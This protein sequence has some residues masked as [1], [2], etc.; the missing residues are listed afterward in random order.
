VHRSAVVAQQNVE[1]A[2]SLLIAFSLLDNLVDQSWPK[3]AD[4]LGALFGILDGVVAQVEAV[5]QRIGIDAAGVFVGGV[6]QRR[7]AGAGSDLLQLLIL[8][9][10]L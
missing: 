4:Q 8:V 5:R 7:F 10:G 3:L 9:T 2:T 6:G 1:T